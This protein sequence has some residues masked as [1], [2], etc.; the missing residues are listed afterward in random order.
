REEARGGADD[1]RARELAAALLVGAQEVA[2]LALDDARLARG[3]GRVVHRPS[4]AEEGGGGKRR[5]ESPHFARCLTGRFRV[6]GQADGW[7]MGSSSP[8]SPGRRGRYWTGCRVW[9]PSARD[10]GA[11]IWVTARR[12]PSC[13]SAR[14]SIAL[15]G[16]R[17]SRPRR[18][19]S[20]RRGA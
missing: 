1:E 17:R 4:L 10:G 11:A 8:R 7:W 14:A 2:Q 5:A 16:P 15:G 12:W 19:S 18:A 9:S 3:L 20:C 13:R 6:S